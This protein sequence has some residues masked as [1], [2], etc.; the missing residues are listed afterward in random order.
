MLPVNASRKRGLKL[1][2]KALH[3]GHPPETRLGI[4][5]YFPASGETPLTLI[6]NESASQTLDVL[7]QKGMRVVHSDGPHDCDRW[8]PPD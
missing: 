3:L 8:H 4:L 7:D 1:V 2:F 6:A 5:L